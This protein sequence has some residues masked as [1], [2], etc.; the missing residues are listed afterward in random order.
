MTE[1]ASASFSLIDH[2]SVGICFMRYSA[3]NKQMHYPRFRWPHVLWC[4]SWEMEGR[5]VEVV[6]GT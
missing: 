6:P 1:L 4:W 5:A 2:T 3:H